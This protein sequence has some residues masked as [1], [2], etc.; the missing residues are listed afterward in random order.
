MPVLSFASWYYVVSHLQVFGTFCFTYHFVHS[1][2]VVI[3]LLHSLLHLVCWTFLLHI[4]R[5]CF[6]FWFCSLRK[7]SFLVIAFPIQIVAPLNL[8]LTF[9]GGTKFYLVH[10]SIFPPTLGFHFP[11]IWSIFAVFHDLSYS[12]LFS[13]STTTLFCSILCCLALFPRG[14]WKVNLSLNQHNSS[15]S[16][17]IPS[18]FPFIL[19]LLR[20]REV[21]QQGGKIW[22]Y[23]LNCDY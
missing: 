8:L 2:S 7:F 3:F 23:I 19:T 6:I 22:N 15:W 11:L 12:N 1:H 13:I 5:C 18:C 16:E 17:L 14:T 10:F 21:G 9:S 20:A 4:L